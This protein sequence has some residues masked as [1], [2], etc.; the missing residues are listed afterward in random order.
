MANLGFLPDELLSLIGDPMLLDVP[1]A[2][3]GIRTMAFADGGYNDGT[4]IP[5]LVKLKVRK[6]VSVMLL[7]PA[8]LF[9]DDTSIV[10]DPSIWSV[11]LLRSFF[12]VVDPVNGL[13]AALFNVG[14][15]YLNYIFDLNSNGE[16]QLVK[17][18]QNMKA[19]HEAGNPLITTLENLAVVENPFW[20]TVAG[21]KVDLTVVFVLGV[22]SKFSDQ[23]DRDVAPPP[24]G[25]NLLRTVSSPTRTCVLFLMC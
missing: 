21:E 6:I 25:K 1:T 17:F 3:S 11:F 22:P 18:Y 19:Q 24:E 8:G 14:G 20:G 16:N 13:N 7:T 10:A 23:V 15:E 4:A 2:N 9:A 12:G 5:A